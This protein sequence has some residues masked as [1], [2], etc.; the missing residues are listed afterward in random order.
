MKTHKLVLGSSSKAR[1]ELLSRLKIPFVVSSPNIDESRLE[2]ESVQDMVLRLAEQKAKKVGEAYPD[3]YII[4]C[5]QAGIVDNTILGKPLTYENAI[6][7]LQLKSGKKIRFY[8]GLY[9]LNAKN[10]TCQFSVE[11]Y[12]VYIRHLTSKMIEN[13]LA[14]EDVL[15]CAGSLHIEGLGITLVEKLDGDDYTTLIGLPLIR[16]SEMLTNENF[17]AE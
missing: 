14:N 6:Q 7:Q 3:S 11:K 12:D 9:F 2:G 17:F 4:G 15:Q 8:T 10:N 16:L 13:Y 5:D 1:R